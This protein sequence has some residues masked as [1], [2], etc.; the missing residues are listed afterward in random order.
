MTIK[1]YNSDLNQWLQYLEKGVDGGR[2]ELGLSRV[3]YV[4]QQMKLQTQ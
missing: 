4:R 3:E 2:I 1:L